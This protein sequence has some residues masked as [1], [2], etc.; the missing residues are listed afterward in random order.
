M[1]DA[2]TALR[3]FVWG[4]YL[5]IPLLLLTGLFLTILLKGLQ[6]RELGPS[7]YLALIV[8]KDPEGDGDVSHFQ[9][10]T[11]ALAATVGTGNIVGVATAIALGGPGALFWMWMTGLVGMATK[12]SEALLGVMYRHTDEAGEK[13]GG[14][15]FY[16]TRGIGGPVGRYLGI[17][18]A[19]AAAVAAFG[20]GNMVQSN[21]TTTNIEAAFGVPVWISAL[22]LTA[23]A[24]VVILGGIRS[25][26]RVTAVFVPVMALFYIVCA[27]LVLL[28]NITA[29][30]AAF[31]TIVTSAFTGTAATG[32]FVG[33]GVA[34][35]IQFGVARGI[36]SNESGLG[37]GGIAAA[38]AQTR[39]PVRQAMVSMTQ[40]FID[41]LVIC[42]FTGLAIVTSGV[43]QAG[44]DGSDF[45][46]QAFASALGNIGPA[47]VAVGLAL[48]AFSTLLGWAYYGERNLEY[49]FGRRAVFPYRLVFIA[50][51]FIGAFQFS[52]EAVFTFSDL[53]NG[54][55]ALPNLIG[56]LLLS[57]VILRETR[58]YFRENPR[59]ARRSGNRRVR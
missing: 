27:T 44:G 48:F 52:L 55:M 16:L 6:F 4:Q 14:P 10:L 51:I 12:Y 9:A 26:G 7:L 2:I 30:P 35:A 1:L 59:S 17:F 23:L 28:V 38:A 42:T 5:L 43:W 54:L 40:T 33:A 22:V 13:S 25:I 19:V 3:D 47:V 15:A 41:T 45:T 18:F 31:V 21:A 29:I 49:L 50:A 39:E 11:T 36:F 58:R 53:A 32:G 56:L 37:T 20:I 57:G 24:A 46:Q 34:A 8:R